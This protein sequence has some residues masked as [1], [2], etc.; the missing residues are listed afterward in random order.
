[1]WGLHIISLITIK[2]DAAFAAMKKSRNHPGIRPYQ[3]KHS[4]LFKLGIIVKAQS[5]VPL[6][7]YVF[8]IRSYRHPGSVRGG[9]FR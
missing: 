3:Q 8:S 1:M 5:D 4:N 9:F 2:R 6:Q 7:F